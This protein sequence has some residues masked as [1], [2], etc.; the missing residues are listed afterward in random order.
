[1]SP[2]SHVVGIGAGIEFITVERDFAT[3][4][5]GSGAGDGG[6]FKWDASINGWQNDHTLIA[7]LL[8]GRSELLDDPFGIGFSL[9][10]C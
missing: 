1:M 7:R 6:C 3:T 9:F 4:A 2:P 10:R 8:K 5:A